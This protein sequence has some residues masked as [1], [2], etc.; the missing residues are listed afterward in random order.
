MWVARFKINGEKGSMGSRTKKYN[1]S[2][3]GYPI[4]FYE[5]N[6]GIHIYLIGFVLGNDR[7]K[8]A[9]IKDLKTS[10]K[11]VHLENKG[12]LIMAQILEPLN[13][14]K[15]YSHKL[16]NLKPI[17]IDE[18][19]F[20]YWTLGSWDKKE[21]IRFAKTVEKE[22]GG[23]LMSVSE[24]KIN[25]FSIIHMQPKTT[26]K[27][28][29]AME[30]AIKNGYY[31]YPRKIGLERLAKIMKISYSTYQAHLRK[32]EKKLLPFFFERV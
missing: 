21:L 31:E 29:Q 13:L 1:I 14:K 9:F 8:K 5:T 7:N 19:G 24:E 15:M 25:D 30:L 2:V 6:K 27:Q 10:K 28:N 16:I 23:E 22:Y 4:S 32:A 11:V 20:N 18:K 26:K 17:F 3:Q 12:N